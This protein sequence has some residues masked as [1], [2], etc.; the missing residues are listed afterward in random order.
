MTWIIP[1]HFLSDRSFPSLL[2]FDIVADFTALDPQDIFDG[3]R[4]LTEARYERDLY[5]VF[6][7]CASTQDKRLVAMHKTW[8]EV[9]YSIDGFSGYAHSSQRALG[10][11]CT[12]LEEPVTYLQANSNV[13][14]SW[15]Q[16]SDMYFLVPKSYSKRAMGFAI[17]GSTIVQAHGESK[18]HE[19]CPYTAD[20]ERPVQRC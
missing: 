3:I 1:D 19:E 2:P 15:S 20:N 10:L 14:I 4:G 13:E 8:F 7:E 18:Y 9:S 17:S 5:R 16:A 6:N 11:S 12:I